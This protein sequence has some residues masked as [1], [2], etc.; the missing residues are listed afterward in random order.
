M[1][2]HAR[3]SSPSSDSEWRSI[4][5]PSENPL[6]Q[7]ATNADLSIPSLRLHISLPPQ[8]IDLEKKAF[9][10]RRYFV[11]FAYTSKV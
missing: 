1:V 5:A 2:V 9:F 7:S 6:F 8:A 10:R 4:S 3:S 11:G